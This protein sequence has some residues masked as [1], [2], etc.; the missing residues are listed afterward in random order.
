MGVPNHGA[1]CTSHTHP[2]SC[3]YC[4]DK[5]Y[6]F[7]CSCGSKLL[8]DELGNPWPRHMCLAMLSDVLGKD[9][10]AQAMTEQ[11]NRP[12]IPRSAPMRDVEEAAR[13]VV[14]RAK[15]DIA[16]WSPVE[17]TEVSGV[18]IL[19]EVVERPNIAKRLGIDRDLDMSGPVVRAMI[20]FMG[21]PVVQVTV[22]LGDIAEGG[23][24]SV[25]GFVSVDE[26]RSAA[27]GVGEVVYVRAEGAVLPIGGLEW[28]VLDLGR[29]AG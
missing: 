7:Q 16:R 20:G 22:V 6:Y 15:R 25:T 28:R 21:A 10:L 1:G 24:S 3:R 2:T 13:C 12:G 4:G 17:G 29:I 14:E 18:G 27:V 23:A 11:I 19:R 26:Y 8:F 5:V 9:V